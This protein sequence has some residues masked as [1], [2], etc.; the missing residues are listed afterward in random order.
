MDVGTRPESKAANDS[1]STQSPAPSD[2]PAQDGNDTPSG[3]RPADTATDSS[4]VTVSVPAQNIRQFKEAVVFNDQEKE[5]A[6]ARAEIAKC[7]D[8]AKRQ[9]TAYQNLQRDMESKNRELTKANAETDDA[10]SLLV[11]RERELSRV[12]G[13]KEDLEAKVSELRQSAV[14]V[15]APP[16]SPNTSLLEEVERLKKD[17]LAKEGSIKSLKIARD[18]IR[19]STKAEVI[20]IQ[21]KYAREQ[22]ELV[23]R[24]EKE[25]TRHRLALASKEA[26]LEQEQE[27]L[28]QLEMDLTMRTS[29][30]EE[31]AAELKASLDTMTKSYQDAQMEIDELKAAA[32]AENKAR[33][34][35]HRSEVAKYTRAMKRD[36]KRIADLETA[37][38]K[39]KEH[40][41]EHQKQKTRPRPKSTSTAAEAISAAIE[42]VAD[43]AVEELR[44]EVATLRVDAVH[45]DE[46]IRKLGVMV[47]ELE[48]KQNPEGGRRPRGKVATLQAEIDQLKAD[49]EVR[50]QKIEKLET[51][52]H[53]T[54][55]TE[56]SHSEIA[57]ELDL[58]IIALE[59]DLKSRVQRTTEL[60]RELKEAQEAANERPMRLRHSSNSKRSAAAGVVS[61]AATSAAA[62]PQ[63]ATA[64]R[65]GSQGARGRKAQA[66]AKPDSSKHE[67]LYVEKLETEKR[68][69]Q[70]IVTEQQVKIMHLR[71]G[72]GHS[73]PPAVDDARPALQP[74]TPRKRAQD[75]GEEVA[76]SGTVLAKRPKQVP[77]I[78]LAK[79]NGVPAVQKKTANVPSAKQA[80]GTEQ[81]V[82]SIERLLKDK[83]ISSAN[84]AKRFFSILQKTPQKLH[85]SLLQ[86]T[87]EIPEVDPAEF[88]KTLS[89]HMASPGIGKIAGHVPRRLSSF[90]SDVAMAVWIFAYKCDRVQFFGNLM[91]LLAQRTISGS[92]RTVAATCS[93]ARIFAALCFLAQDIQ[94]LR[95]LLCDLLM[96]AVDQAHTLPVIANTTGDQ[97]E[98]SL[99]LVVRVFQ[100][101][102][103]S[104]DEADSLY[105]V[106]VDQCGW[107][108][109]CKAEFADKIFI[110]VEDM[111][112]TLGEDSSEYPV[113]KCAHNLLAPY[114]VSQ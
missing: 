71:D 90:E 2:R 1:A 89:S 88:L 93:L 73:V 36:E 31:N 4:N 105:S 21:A 111:L 87:G 110:E 42:D 3:N 24:Q 113:V 78:S 98:P 25:M 7:R 62:A 46:T 114:I 107:R 84:R 26:E 47:E 97:T 34:S 100:A 51:A 102:Q 13:L 63:T 75:V 61:A 44:E 35:E 72:A 80:S 53:I 10:R 14:S 99:G 39:A 23:D 49:L 20:S 52:L 106:M 48:R 12:R 55:G 57:A 37:L 96:E 58:K 38:A 29:Q 18:S 86:I 19:S 33:G 104:R 30:L 112:R 41:K 43:M 64:G 59:S 76:Q 22:A 92:D 108:Q 5:L 81:T 28:M 11:Q 67:A 9:H 16:K 79:Q 56:V 40:A 74:I 65:G 83:R 15:G 27:R 94:R 32:K 70:E 103:H 54:E 50:D 109:P 82:E 66:E 60:E 68:A 17:L 77:S 6:T 8:E 91:R 95:V 85:A 45:K 101:D 69:L